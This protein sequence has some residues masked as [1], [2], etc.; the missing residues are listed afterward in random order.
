MIP[1]VLTWDSWSEVDLIDDGL[2]CPH[3]NVGPLHHYADYEGREDKSFLHLCPTLFIQ[4][5][6]C[7]AVADQAEEEPYECEL[8]DE[9]HQT[10]RD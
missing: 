9:C 1:K 4:C 2:T 7:G 8:W 5:N 3:S 10:K 6:D